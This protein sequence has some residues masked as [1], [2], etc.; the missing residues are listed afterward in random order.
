MPVLSLLLSAGW[1]AG[2]D[3]TDGA[4]YHEVQGKRERE[5]REKKRVKIKKKLSSQQYADTST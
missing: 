4:A 5:E 2:T 3:A 1:L